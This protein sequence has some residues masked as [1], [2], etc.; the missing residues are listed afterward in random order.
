MSR[1]SFLI[2]MAVIAPALAI[3]ST[4]EAAPNALACDG[5]MRA[6]SRNVSEQS[7]LALT[8]DLDAGSVKVGTSWGVSPIMGKPENTLVFGTGLEPSFGE[9]SGSVNRTTGEASVYIKTLT[10]GV[11]RFYGTCKKAQ[12]LW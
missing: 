4:T 12:T 7:T 5:Q 1:F 9:P 3:S 6:V 2:R 11:Y 10:D 8:I